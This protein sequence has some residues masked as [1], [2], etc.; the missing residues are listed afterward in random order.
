MLV[1]TCHWIHL[2]HHTYIVPIG[3]QFL[4]IATVVVAF[5]Y[6]HIICFAVNTVAY[7]W[8]VVISNCTWCFGSVQYDVPHFNCM[9][10]CVFVHQDA[11]TNS[12]G[13]CHGPTD[14]CVY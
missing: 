7:V 13:W 14:N 3:D 5:A 6:D 12:Y 2:F 11:V 8:C 1:S 10:I 9:H 4:V